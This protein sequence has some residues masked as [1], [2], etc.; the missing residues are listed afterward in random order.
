MSLGKEHLE[1]PHRSHGM[2]HERYEWSMLAD[3]KPVQWPD[4]SSLA[5]WVNVSLQFFPMN[6]NGVP[7]AP[8]GGMTMPYPDLRHYTLRD[9]GNRVGIYRVLDALQSRDIRASFAVNGQ[10]AERNPGLVKTL[11]EYGEIVAHGWNMDTLHYGGL[12]MNLEHEQTL[13]TLEALRSV[14]GQSIRGWLSPARNESENTPELIAENG[15]DYL[16]DWVNDDMPYPFFTQQGPLT[17]LPLSTELEDRF[18]I[19]N[20]QHSEESWK[21]QVCDAG[22]MLLSEARAEG[23]EGE[24]GAGRLLSLSLHPWLIG[25]PHRISKLEAVLDYLQQQPGVWTASPAEIVDCW[26]SQQ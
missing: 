23:V 18:V 14:S 6:Q 17:A 10:L 21:E 16:C 8:P 12:D 20:N 3:R 26:R 2:D 9:Y 24:R 7:F 1:Y 22:D 11:A 25:Q 19:Q 13:R 5:L 4:N 15:I